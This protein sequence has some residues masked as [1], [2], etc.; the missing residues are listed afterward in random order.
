MLPNLF[1][2]IIETIQL[3]P[4]TP[5]LHPSELCHSQEWNSD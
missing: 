2:V 5:H 4:E 1:K 3:R